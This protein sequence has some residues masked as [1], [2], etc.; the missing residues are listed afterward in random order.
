MATAIAY[1]E[2]RQARRDNITRAST[3]GAAAFPDLTFL[4]LLFGYRSF[5]E[6]QYAFADCDEAQ[7]LLTALFPKQASGVWPVA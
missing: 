7:A 4:Q 1:H 3:G 6:L 5:E 2:T